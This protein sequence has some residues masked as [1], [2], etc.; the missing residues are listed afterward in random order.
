MFGYYSLMSE[1]ISR[2]KNYRLNEMSLPAEAESKKEC[3][4]VEFLYLVKGLHEQLLDSVDYNVINNLQD[5]KEK[6]REYLSKETEKIVQ[7]KR[8]P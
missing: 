2:K 8:M 4:E 5:E 3:D 1:V 6:L 7:K